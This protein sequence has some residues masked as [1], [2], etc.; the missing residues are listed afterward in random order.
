MSDLR[1]HVPELAL[2]WADES[3]EK[4]WRQYEGTL[5]FADISG[6]TA[7]GER[8]AQRGRVGGEELVETLSRVF[9]QMLD[10]ADQ[11]GG[12][13]LKFGGDALLLFFR[14]ECHATQAASAAVEMRRVLR[15][16]AEIATSVGPLRLSMSIGLHSGK[17]DFFLVGK[18]HRELVLLGPA[19]NKVVEVENAANARE[20]VVS[21]ET[22]AQLPKGAT[23][24]RKDGPLLLRWRK[25][26]ASAS[27]R[28][29]GAEYPSA[30]VDSL[31][32]DELGR[33]LALGAPD[34][35]HRVACIA[36]AGFSGTDALLVSHG[37]EALAAQL[38]DTVSTV[39][40]ILLDEGVT[41]L[42]IDLDRD[43]GKF[44]MGAGVPHGHEDDEGLMLR[45]MRRIADSEMPLPLSIGVNRGHVFVAEVGTSRRAAYSAMGDT[46][47][48]A[49]RIAAQT[50]PGSIYAHPSV[51]DESL[52][53]FAVEEAGPL[54]MKGKTA[55]QIVYAVGE[56]LGL[57]EREGLEVDE[58]IGRITEVSALR[59]AIQELLADPDAATA[60]GRRGRDLVE[61]RADVRVYAARI[62]EIV[63]WHLG[64]S[65]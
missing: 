20:I 21:P 53:R 62:A 17:A 31:F 56:E 36:F 37:P 27:G 14:G 63:R 16:T 35:E 15:G 34:P 59:R 3:P 13:L 6:F 42:A 32:S 23:N 51:L 39:Q 33:H 38:H 46:T 50:P 29:E 1:R 57:R 43:G 11:R 2:E 5:C 48:T 22:V 24:P 26:P 49:A 40:H 19:A 7:L 10:I 45:A 4:L 25:A 18:P 28:H 60:M 55:P 64:A 65:Q 52:T 8:L 9:S 47:N 41:L 61:T 12:S 44:F 30:L 58:F 54:T